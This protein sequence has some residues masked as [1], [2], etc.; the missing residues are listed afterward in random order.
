MIVRYLLFIDDKVEILFSRANI[1]MNMN[2]NMN[3]N[4]NMNMNMNKNMNNE[5]VL[6]VEDGSRS[7]FKKKNT[8][9]DVD[10]E[11]QLIGLSFFIIVFVVT[12]PYLLFNYGYIGLLE[13]YIPNVD[14]VATVLGFQREPFVK[15]KSYFKYLYNPDSDTVYGYFSQT[16]INYLALLGM[17]FF[18]AYYTFINK[19]ISKGWARAFIMVP[20]TYLLPGNF[21]AYYME[22]ISQYLDKSTDL[23]NDYV[24][25]M[26]VY[27]VGVIVI[28]FFIYG[29]KLLIS[30]FGNYLANFLSKYLNI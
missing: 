2:K 25:D 22:K 27:G 4:I 7:V 24:K 30:F 18:V 1:N 28:L 17:S 15:Y 9:K 26:L 21:I 29:E 16:F 6:N 23:K 14:M 11:K 12:I 19:S 10:V 20:M 13:G 5:G 8:D 3:M